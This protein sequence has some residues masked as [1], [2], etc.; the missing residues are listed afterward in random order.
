MAW[1]GLGCWLMAMVMTVAA[2]QYPRL[3]QLLTEGEACPSL[4]GYP[5]S[6]CLGIKNCP[7]VDLYISSGRL[8]LNEVV[9]CGIGAYMELVCCPKQPPNMQTTFVRPLSHTEYMS[10]RGRRLYPH[11][12]SLRYLNPVTLDSQIFRCTAF[13]LKENLALSS[14]ACV[15]SVIADPNHVQ[16][17]IEEPFKDIQE[18]N[19]ITHHNNDLVLIRMRNGYGREFIAEICSQ[20]DVDNRLKLVAVGFSQKNEENC[21]WFEKEVTIF[22]FHSCDRVSINRPLSG[23]DANNHLCVTPGME[24]QSSTPGAC[25]DCLRGSASGL[26]A[27]RRDGSVCLLGIATPTSKSCTSSTHPLYYTSLLG[28]SNRR[29]LNRS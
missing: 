26:H 24:R 19:N 22:T 29:F 15:G 10:E 25:V 18:I 21:Q 13:L 11:V 14:A 8:T 5:D 16:L 2:V 23:I 4:P 27:I 28:P 12:A 17:G 6:S 1:M 20:A 3:S 9:Q 7:N